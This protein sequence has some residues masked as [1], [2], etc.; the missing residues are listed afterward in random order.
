[1]KINWLQIDHH[2][3]VVFKETHGRNIFFL[4]ALN[5]FEFVAE[6]QEREMDIHIYI[7][8]RIFH[9]DYRGN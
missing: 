5:D 2:F 4:K 7:K 1:M 3:L 9:F 8:E 6:Q